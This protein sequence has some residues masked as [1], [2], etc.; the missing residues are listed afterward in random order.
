METLEI[1][2]TQWTTD[3]TNSVQ[4][5]AWGRDSNGTKHC[6]HVD[7]FTPF[8]Y[9]YP[10]NGVEELLGKLFANDPARMP[11]LVEDVC[12][13]KL[14]F[15]EFENGV[16]RTW[17]CARCS[18]ESNADFRYIANVFE[19]RKYKV[20]EKNIPPLLQFI[21]ERQLKTVGWHKFCAVRRTAD[22]F[23]T[24][25]DV[26]W[27]TTATQVTCLPLRI[28]FPPFVICS[29]DI[30][31]YSSV[32]SRMPHADVPVDAIFQ[33]SCVLR[34]RKILLHIKPELH[35]EGVE[36]VAFESETEL[37]V[38]FV[39]LLRR[40]KPDMLLGYNTLGF[41]FKYIIDR[42]QNRK[43]YRAIQDMTLNLHK[44]AEVDEIN[45]SS[46]AFKNQQFVFVE[47]E[48]VVII[49][50]LPIIRRDYKLDS[51]KLDAVVGHFLQAAKDDV[52]P[53]FLF[54]AWQEQNVGH[55]EKVGKYCVHDSELVLQLFDK[56]A[57]CSTM[58]EMASI[59]YINLF[60]TFARGQQLKVFSQIYRHCYK[61]II[62]DSI[63]STGEP[64]VG[65]RVFDPTPQLTTNVVSFDFESLYP[66]VIKAKN[67]CYYSFVTSDSVPD[68][69]CHVLEWEDHQGCE[70]DPKWARKCALRGLRN[71]RPEEYRERE[72]L[73]SY[74]PVEI[75]AKRRFRFLRDERESVVP[76][77]ITT[78][79]E[80]RKQAKAD[81]KRVDPSS[82]EYMVLN[83]RQL[84]LKV[85]ANS[86]YGFFGVAKGFLPFLPAAMSITY[87][88][89]ETVLRAADIIRNQFG[90]DI[91]YGDTDSVYCR[92]KIDM[93]VPELWKFA[94]NVAA[95]VTS[96]FSRPLNL[97]FEDAIYT[98]YLLIMKKRYIY[99]SCGVD[100][101][102]K[103]ELGKKG[104]LLI[105]RD[106][107]KWVKAV[108][109]DIINMVFDN[110]TLD[111]VV[112]YL[113][114]AIVDLIVGRV[115]V[116]DLVITKSIGDNNDGKCSGET[117]DGKM[118]IGDYIIPK[119]TDA[120]MH[121]K[122]AKN[123]QE[124]IYFSLPAQIQLAMRMRSRGAIV[125]SGS[126]IAYVVTDLDNWRG[127]SGAKIEDVVYYKNNKWWL[128]LD[129]LYYIN[130]LIKPLD[131]LF[132]IVYRR[133][134]VMK[135]MF[136]L[137]VARYNVCQVLRRRHV[138]EMVA[139]TPKI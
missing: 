116:A 45:W 86:I 43:C 36:C 114:A 51:F 75:C 99:R 72:E 2:V 12:L 106:N 14:Y 63:P 80:H 115:N 41:D 100:G 98:K 77:I 132:W 3:V 74:K 117:E 118:R 47:I 101:V 52:T 111:D 130:S 1:F 66:S 17:D 69:D 79:L 30:E 110:A 33:I 57:T 20:F 61:R 19:K 97:Q 121:T 42:C 6:V 48:G 13:P 92:F 23:A 71:L 84:A 11:V 38:G 7:D 27:D 4:F 46:S 65:A 70:H 73:S 103:S 34:G 91:L 32:P 50:M 108:Y 105:R 16:R 120:K 59:S 24:L 107:C 113:R 55:L 109:A 76:N 95:Q 96:Q 127:K 10:N 112:A 128:S 87:L 129:Y 81:M 64:Y 138:A 31:A 18:F 90:A 89:R 125:E 124:Y 22:E 139:R 54:R 44:K 25:A 136:K 122:G 119:N 26:E 68:A 37:L 40:L 58:I 56:L 137:I 102:E 88:G 104:V 94:Q 126:R 133:D 78:L 123:E 8:C 62:V 28:E 9:I 60:D 49:D 67:I 131:Q 15:A 135:Q 93:P 82:F 85:S 53:Q 35:V 39:D 29:F 21:C 134:G 83:A 5:R